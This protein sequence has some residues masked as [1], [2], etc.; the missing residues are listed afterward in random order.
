MADVVALGPLPSQRSTKSR[1][2]A[3][4]SF[5]RR[6]RETDSEVVEDAPVAVAHL[7]AVLAE[8]QAEVRVLEAVAEPGVEAAGALE[9][10]A[11]DEH[12]GGGHG[13]EAARDLL[14]AGWSAG[15]AGVD[16]ARVAVL[17]DDDARV[18]DGVVREQQLAADDGDAGLARPRTATSASSQPASGTCRC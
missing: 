7:V 1:C 18:L 11:A 12:A 13:L 14:T 10:V 8:P 16:V 17:A 3:A 9:R 4:I 6:P 2:C 5:E 15:K